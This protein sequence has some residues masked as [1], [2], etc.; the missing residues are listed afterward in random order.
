MG[1]IRGSRRSGRN[2]AG[3]PA[4][5]PLASRRPAGQQPGRPAVAAVL[6]GAVAAGA[7]VAGIDGRCHIQCKSAAYNVRNL[8]A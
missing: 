6:Q 2:V 8:S 5:Q 4:G 7:V 3:P 1:N